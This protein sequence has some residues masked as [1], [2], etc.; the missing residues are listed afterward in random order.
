[1]Q[2]K[3]WGECMLTFDKIKVP[4]RLISYCSRGLVSRSTVTI[5][6]FAI[7]HDPNCRSLALMPNA[8]D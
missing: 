6:E 1:M 2:S 8:S 4:V 7:L 5:I 3:D